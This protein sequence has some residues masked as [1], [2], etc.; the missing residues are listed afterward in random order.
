MTV[1]KKSKNEKQPI[2]WQV[3]WVAVSSGRG[4]YSQTSADMKLK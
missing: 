2:M 1:M 4:V 3:E